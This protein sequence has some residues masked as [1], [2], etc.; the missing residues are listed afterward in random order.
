LGF[1]LGIERNA[2]G[3]AITGFARP[4]G[5]ALRADG[6]I[7]VADMSTHAVF[8]LSPALDA[9]RTLD[10]ETGWSAP[11]RIEQGACERA[12]DRPPAFFNGPH[13]IDF[14]PDGGFCVTCYYDPALHFFAPDGSHRSTLSRLSPQLPLAGPATATY[15]QGGMLLVTEYRLGLVIEL[16]PGGD[17][18][19]LLGDRPAE[20]GVKLERPHMARRLADG[21]V[22]VADTWNHRLVIVGDDGRALRWWGLPH[23]G[24]SPGWHSGSDPARP[25]DI[26]GALQ[27]PVSIDL[28]PDGNSILVADWGNHRLQQIP[29]KADG[30]IVALSPGLKSPYDARYFDGR[31]LIAD[32][33][34]GRVLVTAQPGQ[35]SR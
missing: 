35:S 25:G 23:S 7:C 20:G 29:L 1:H 6:G 16:D 8:I 21:N 10:R 22:L 2:T 11:I 19:R 27:A 34:N 30:P 32:S 15:D 12:P 28:S 18:S 13:S 14:A 3:A 31:L 33:H 4:M 9:F 5:L 24:G 17:V 26:A